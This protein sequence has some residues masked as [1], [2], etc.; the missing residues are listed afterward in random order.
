MKEECNTKL[1]HHYVTMGISKNLQVQYPRFVRSPIGES[2]ASTQH[3]TNMC[4][5]NCNVDS[6]KTNL[7]LQYPRFARSPLGESQA[8]QSYS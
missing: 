2:Q 7:Q 6:S 4:S 5:P 1:F 3:N 8:T